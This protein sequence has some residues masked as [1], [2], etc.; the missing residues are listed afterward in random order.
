M[1]GMA[2][3]SAHV[4]HVGQ[5][6]SLAVSPPRSRIPPPHTH[7]KGSMGGVTFSMLDA[8]SIGSQPQ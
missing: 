4:G 6:R 1:L 8:F 2:Q 5:V 7:T 3:S